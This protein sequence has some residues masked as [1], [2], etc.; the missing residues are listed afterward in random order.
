LYFWFWDRFPEVHRRD[1]IYWWKY[2]ND[3]ARIF[4]GQALDALEQQG[5]D[6]T[7]QARSYLYRA[8]NH[9]PW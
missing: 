3:D 2:N 9:L 8:L 7:V 5:E 1:T 6:G 4:I